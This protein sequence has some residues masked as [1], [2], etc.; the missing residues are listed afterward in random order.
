MHVVSIH[1]RDESVGAG[2]GTRA[3]RSRYEGVDVAEVK[4]RVV[5]AMTVP[6]EILHCFCACGPNEACVC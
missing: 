1:R 4:D 5:E 2:E 6:I 3:M